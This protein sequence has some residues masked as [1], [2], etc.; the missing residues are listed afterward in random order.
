MHGAIPPLPFMPSHSNAKLRT[1]IFYF[2]LPQY[3]VWNVCWT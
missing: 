3:Y 2:T 1:T